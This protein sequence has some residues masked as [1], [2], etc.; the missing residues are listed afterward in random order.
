[1]TSDALALPSRHDRDQEARRVT[2]RPGEVI[3][4]ES[5]YHLARMLQSAGVARVEQMG[6][7]RRHAR[8]TEGLPWR[9][10]RSNS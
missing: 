8:G 5:A 6:G 1:M 2:Y 7:R 3:L 10:T 4:A 9:A